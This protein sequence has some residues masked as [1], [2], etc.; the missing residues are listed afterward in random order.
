MD[1]GLTARCSPAE[2]AQADNASLG[3]AAQIEA[4]SQAGQLPVDGAEARTPSATAGS[5]S[6]P[7]DATFVSQS[8]PYAATPA[9]P[10][11]PANL[12]GQNL[13]HFEI[14][15]LIGGGGM[16]LVFRADDTALDRIVAIKILSTHRAA[17][18]ETIRRFRNEA[19][20]AARL[21]HENIARVYYVGEARSPAM[22][23]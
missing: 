19:Q 8:P 2:P 18:E 3:D 15:E 12:V 14:L 7:N 16:G 5:S 17:D 22:A 1:V 20:S 9:L 13:D 21:D 4:A 11:G 6:R 23:R 10:L